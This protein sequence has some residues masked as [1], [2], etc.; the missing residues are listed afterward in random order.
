M[1]EVEY[2]FAFEPYVTLDLRG[3]TN[4]H[5]VQVNTSTIDEVILPDGTRLTGDALTDR[6]VI[7]PWQK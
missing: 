5:H 1:E 7:T 6:V 2:P 4:L 3:A